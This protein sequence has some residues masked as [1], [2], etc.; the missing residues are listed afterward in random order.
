MR[1]TAYSLFELV[2][3]PAAA[4]S[5]VETVLRSATGAIDGLAAA[6]ATGALATGTIVACRLRLSALV[7]ERERSP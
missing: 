2:A 3:W 5:V 1:K 6:A 4:W 7:S